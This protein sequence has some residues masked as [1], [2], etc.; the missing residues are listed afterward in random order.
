MDPIEIEIRN[1]IKAKGK[2]HLSIRDQVYQAAQSAIDRMPEASR[3]RAQARLF[4]AIK[5][6]EEQ[7]IREGMTG[8]RSG[9][10][11]DRRSAWA[12]RL[13]RVFRSPGQ[14]KHWFFR[15]PL[16]TV[17]TGSLVALLVLAGFLHVSDPAS[18]TGENELK[19]IVSDASDAGL[20]LIYSIEF[21]ADIE[22]VSTGPKSPDGYAQDGYRIWEEKVYVDRNLTIH[23]RELI[24][25]DR[26]KI[27]LMTVELGIEPRNAI[28]LLNAGFST[29]SEAGKRLQN[30]S[31]G[32][33][34]FLNS[35][36]VEVGQDFSST[37]E[38][39]LL[40]VFDWADTAR[41]EQ[42]NPNTELF[43]PVAIIDV[44]DNGTKVWIRRI[45]IEEVL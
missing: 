33:L 2:A 11:S 18:L 7:Y 8:E 22:T 26:D 29:H 38:I 44:P 15:K 36:K 6:I 12:N 20:R 45:A 14:F 43:K 9:R 21:P 42:V 40:G 32:D 37:G 5:S 31:G 41:G 4:A 34:Y 24:P 23:G 16:V 3:K 19:G 13:E 30:G 17:F 25:L 28:V 10:R 27:Y 39:Q 1:A 35:G